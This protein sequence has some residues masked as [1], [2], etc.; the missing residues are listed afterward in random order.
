[1]KI[2][3]PSSHHPFKM[4]PPRSEDRPNVASESQS[5]TINH[6]S[7]SQQATRE[8]PDETP[9]ANRLHLSNRHRIHRILRPPR[10]IHMLSGSCIHLTPSSHTVLL[11]IHSVFSVLHISKPE[12]WRFGP[13]KLACLLVMSNL[14][15]HRCHSLHLLS[16]FHFDFDVSKFTSFNFSLACCHTTEWKI[17]STI[18]V[19]SLVQVWPFVGIMEEI[20]GLIWFCDRY[21][22]QLE[23]Q[24]VK[25]GVDTLF[26]CRCRSKIQIFP[27]THKYEPRQRSNS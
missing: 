10:S 15:T 24:G 23:V 19:W 26:R 2:D 11:S 9:L 13:L 25:L 12:G 18:P 17:E 16:P 5:S 8:A 27:P 14:S 6:K 22:G 7:R 3:F 20:S 21:T 1:M 4:G